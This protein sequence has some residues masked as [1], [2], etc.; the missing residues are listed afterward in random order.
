MLQCFPMALHNIYFILLWHD[1]AYV[2]K[3]PLNTK[4]TDRQ[5]DIEARHTV[6]YLCGDHNTT[7]TWSTITSTINTF[8][9]LFKQLKFPDIRLGPPNDNLWNCWCR[10]ITGQS[11]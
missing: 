4:Q 7:T 3:V 9:F 10:C 6:P 2:L 11:G 8:V 1:I 5:T